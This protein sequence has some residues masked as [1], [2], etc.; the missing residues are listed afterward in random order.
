MN[1]LVY[2]LIGLALGAIIGGL[3]GWLMAFRR[4]PANP[5]DARVEN[6]LREQLLQRATDISKLRAQ[7]AETASACAT[8]EARQDAAEKLLGEQRQLHEQHLAEART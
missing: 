7:L 8:A 5:S 4:Q 6:E 3:V 1:P 2:L